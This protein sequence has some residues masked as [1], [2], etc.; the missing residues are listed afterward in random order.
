MLKTCEGSRHCDAVRFRVLLD[1]SAGT[2]KCSGGICLRMRLWS[3]NADVDTFTLTAG[4]EAMTDAM[5]RN[6]VAHHFFCATCGSHAF[7][8]I[9]LPNM[10]GQVCSNFAIAHFDGLDVE[11]LMAAPVTD[12]DGLHDT[13]GRV[14]D[15]V[16]H[17]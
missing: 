17:L 9:D 5:G 13:W 7:D 10:L 4:A 15:E 6:A 11:E 14:P 3:V 8:R 12:Y 16:Q 2:G 1:V